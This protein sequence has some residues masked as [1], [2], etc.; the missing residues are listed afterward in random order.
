[1][2]Q[3]ARTSAPQWR[4]TGETGRVRDLLPVPGGDFLIVRH[5]LK[6]SPAHE[7]HVGVFQPDTTAATNAEFAAFITVAGYFKVVERPL[8]SA[9]YPDV[10]PEML[11]PRSLVFRLTKGPIGTVDYRHWCAWTP[12]ACWCQPEVPERPDYPTDPDYR[13]RYG[14]RGAIRSY[15]DS[16]VQDTGPLNR[17]RMETTDEETTAAWGAPEGVRLYPDPL[18]LE[19]RTDRGQLRAL[20]SARRPIFPS[21]RGRSRCRGCRSSGSSRAVRSRAT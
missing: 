20:R 18:R 5:Y 11:A 7:A 13:R 8:N 12:G 4:Q 3:D 15:V 9:Q 21:D 19:D 14:S 1:M 17:K 6:A 16:R 2:R 10:R